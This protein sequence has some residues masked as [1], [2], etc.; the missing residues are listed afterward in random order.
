MEEF[1]SGYCRA[2][3]SSR[4]V[5]AE[6]ENGSWEIDCDYGC[7]PHASACPIAEKLRELTS[8]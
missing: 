2:L 1:V 4:V 8:K 5:T 6:L 7:C 3:D